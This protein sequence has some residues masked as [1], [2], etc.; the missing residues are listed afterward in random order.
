[1]ISI[2]FI[3]I[4]LFIATNIPISFSLGLA[5]AITA[6]VK[7][8]VPLI[9][10][11]QKIF[12]ALDSFPLL[13]LPLFVLAGSFLE[14]GGVG[15]RLVNLT[16]VFVRHISGGLGFV[17]IVSTIIFSEVSGSSAA[18]AAAIGS[19]TIPAM[20]RLGYNPAFATAIVAASG[21]MAALIPPSI[22][23][24]IYGWQANTSV[25]AVF[26]GGFLPGFLMGGGLCVYTYFYAKKM[27]FP[28]EKR[29]S[30]GE[31]WAAV[32]KSFLALLMPVIIL[33]GIFAGIFTATEAAAVAVVY[34]FVVAVF[35]YRELKWKDIPR[36]LV[37]SSVITGYVSLLLGFASVFGYLLT[38]EQVPVKLANLILSISPSQWV[39]LLLVNILFLIAGCFLNATAILIVLVP[40]LLP[41]VQ[42]FGIDLV[43]FGIILIANLGIGYVTPPVGTCLYVAC[44]ISKEPL[45]TVIKPLFPYLVVMVIM[46]MFITYIP[47]ISLVI[48]RLIY[49]K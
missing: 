39:F 41:M 20:I 34:G 42:K 40:I 4:A 12:G 47:W 3:L 45:S 35:Y 5:S 10:I 37:E 36:I 24:V 23:G 15:M 32:K 9:L 2:L 33:G 21:G 18:D 28:T 44:G 11:P 14:T 38:V 49:G 31:I 6:C 22:I 48:P 27:N 8:N 7:G 13:A 16:H 30:L 46:L 26:A 1:M 19:V 17:V 25:G 43:H 29:A